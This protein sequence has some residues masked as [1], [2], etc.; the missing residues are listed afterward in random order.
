MDHPVF[1]GTRV[2]IQ[3]APVMRLS[4]RHADDVAR[5]RGPG[6][7]GSHSG[8]VGL[9]VDEFDGWVDGLLG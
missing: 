8:W 9:M 7:A 1:V 4:A 3:S 5:V 6:T 2:C